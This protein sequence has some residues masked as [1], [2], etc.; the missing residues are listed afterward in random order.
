MIRP[1]CIATALL[2]LCQN[3]G[4]AERLTYEQHIRPIFRA[5]CFDCHGATEELEGGLDLR[6]VRL[7]RKGGD[8]GSAIDLEHPNESYLL[9]RIRDGEMPPGEAKVSETELETI[10]RWIAEGAAT[11]RPEADS[12]G[13]GLGVTPEERAYWAYQPI[14]AVA[15]PMIETPSDRRRVH[16]EIDALV[17]QRIAEQ[18]QAL[19]PEASRR[20]LVVRA[21]F[22]LVGLPPSPESIQSWVTDTRADWY[23]RL[24]DHLLGSPAYGERWGRHW[25][26]IAGYADSEGY[27]VADAERP[28]AWKYRD[29]VIRSLNEDMPFDRFITEQLAGDEIAGPISGDLTESQISLLTATGFLRMAA[30]GTG[31]G[32]N[33]DQARNQV[34]ID[35]LK[36][37]GTSLFGLSIQCAQCHDH[38]YDPIPQS[39]YYALRAVFEP[40]LDWKAWKTPNAR[41]VSLYTAEDRAKAADVEAEATEVAETKAEK[42]SE[43]MRQALEE[44]L[45]KYEEPQRELLRK[46]YETPAK[47]RSDEQKQLLSSNPSV[48]ITP[49]NLYQY[50]PDS[51]PKLAEFDQRIQ[52][53]R[54][55]KPVEEFIRALVEPANSA[56]ETKLFH[57][58]D[59]GQPKQKVLPASLTVVSAEGNRVEFPENDQTLPTT[60][61]RLA[62][63][64]WLTSREN[65]LL[66]RVIANRVW[67]H[68]FGK[69]LVSTPADFGKLGTP[70]SDPV[71]LDWLANELIQSGW[72][73]KHLHRVIMNSAVYRQQ[74]AVGDWQFYHRSL[75]RLEAETIRDRML[76][77]TGSLDPRLYGRPLKINADDTGQVVVQGDQSRR[78]LY[79][80]TRRSQ[81]VGM[82]QTFDAPVMETNCESRD[83]STVAT[84]SLMLLNGQFIL[85]QAARLA[86]RVAREPV[87]FN[88]GGN[89]PWEEPLRSHSP[90]WQYG[91][92]AFDPHANRTGGFTPLAHWTGSQWQAGP[93]LPDPDLAYTL[94]NATGGHPGSAANAVIR[95]WTAPAD[96]VVGIVGTLGHSSPNGD[97]VR[98]TIVTSRVGK[99]G[100]WTAQE[101]SVETVVDSIK[102][103]KGDTVDFI[104]DC[105]ENTNSDSFQWKVVLHLENAANAPLSI[106]SESCFQGPGESLERVPGQLIRAWQLAYGRDP[107]DEELALAIRFVVNQLVILEASPEKV[108]AGRSSVRQ[109]MT[110]LCQSLFAS[111]E[112]LYVE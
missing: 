65:P 90:M 47:D 99:V 105:R 24:V 89:L 85:D 2:F 13:I 91:Y 55:K 38:R 112:F 95:R 19:L 87:L 6:Q 100:Q 44:E 54:A 40:A 67:M 77:A 18:K 96:G 49:G 78:S 68:H 103:A 42:L 9:D 48:N 56:A 35:T 33:D 29:W 46:A 31:S 11:V 7:M 17:M 107:S 76:S 79:I 74:V 94:L 93:V 83:S 81:P 104:T 14:E 82:L 23:P 84:Q 36:I 21:Y 75:R 73:M 43:Y 32:S 109:A 62:F 3:A 30:D 66:A 15:V 71:L 5:H 59:H 92:G 80:Q 4:L 28:W 45:Q 41:R 108:P 50:I 20:T 52:Q 39:D 16:T 37:V 8:S 1:S 63:A 60:G 61:R 58:G 12:I 97:G 70:P 72:S 106:V 102:V 53:I 57:R 98:G 51:K 10:R 111:N 27:T 22:D 26:D 69:G 110:N 25:L 101:G 88:K 34:I 86:N 64:R